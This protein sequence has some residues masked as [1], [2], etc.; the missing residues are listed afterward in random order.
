MGG[1]NMNLAN[2][3]DQ[4]LLQETSRL[5]RE[6]RHILTAVLWHLHEIDR[7]RLF[8]DLRCSS[9]FDY[10]VKFLG[11]S[12]DQACR[13]ISA[14][15]LLRELP[16][17]EEKINNG[18]LTLTN[19]GLAQN[20]FRKERNLR[21]FTKTEKLEIIA[22]LEKQPRRLAEKVILAESKMPAMLVPDQIKAASQDT[23]EIKF[24]APEVLQEKIE[25]LKGLLSHKKPNLNLAELFDYL[26]E[27]GLDK[28]DPLRQPEK[29]RRLKTV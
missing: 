25:H 3:S 12:E 29:K 20:L 16:E 17:M 28:L 15:R 11:Y 24:I 10:A 26:C 14:M 27:M 7:R 23:I 6:E 19:I 22:K 2:L 8:S 13:R 18:V 4:E 21:A 9:L 1:K 5:A